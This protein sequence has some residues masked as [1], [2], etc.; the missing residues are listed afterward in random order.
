MKDGGSEWVSLGIEQQTL[1]MG[2][3]VSEIIVVQIQ[4]RYETG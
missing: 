3:I 2:S 1:E 4:V